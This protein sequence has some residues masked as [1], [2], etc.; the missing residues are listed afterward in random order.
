M[1][2]GCFSFHLTIVASLFWNWASLV[3]SQ[4]GSVYIILRFASLWGEK[5][6]NFTQSLGPRGWCA[7]GRR[8]CP[9]WVGARAGVTRAKRKR[10]VVEQ[11]LKWFGSVRCGGI[12]GGWVPDLLKVRVEP[13]FPVAQMRCW[14]GS[15]VKVCSEQL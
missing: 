7:Q 13:G 1:Q 4:V 14:E 6:W 5:K 9:K 10:A 8:A 2:E 3:R 15:W 11:T 12:F